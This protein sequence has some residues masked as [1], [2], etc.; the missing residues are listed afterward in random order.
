MTALSVGYMGGHASDAL[1]SDALV[2]HPRPFRS[3]RLGRLHVGCAYLSAEEMP[4]RLQHRPDD[5]S[6]DE[7]CAREVGLFGAFFHEQGQPDGENDE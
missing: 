6:S 1:E 3:Q 4:D 2:W 7:P 5:I